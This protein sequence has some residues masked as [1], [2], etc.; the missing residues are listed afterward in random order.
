M[1]PLQSVVIATEPAS[2][3]PYPDFNNLV[4]MALHLYSVYCPA[5][6]ISTVRTVRAL[7][8]VLGFL[9]ICNT[10][11]KIVIF[12]FVHRPSLINFGN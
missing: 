2:R 1:F 9:K 11:F 8:F 4:L 5:P 6:I 12:E 10:M 7:N 3:F